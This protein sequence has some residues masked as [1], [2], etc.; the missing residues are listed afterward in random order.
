LI[1]H[2]CGQK[3]SSTIF[4]FFNLL[5]LF[6]VSDVWSVLNIVHYVLEKN[7]YS[8]ALPCNIL[9]MSIMS[10]WSRKYVSLLIFCLYDLSIAKIRCW[11]P[12]LWEL[13]SISPFRSTNICI[14]YLCFF[15]VYEYVFAV[16]IYF[17]WFGV[18]SLHND[19]L[20]IFLLFF[21]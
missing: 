11:S 6:F 14:I 7:V 15:I 5:K 8:A 16:V 10:T 4:I 20:C 18:L 13:Q 1:I 3:W 19:L 12:L 17:S 21:T 2:Y 9:Y